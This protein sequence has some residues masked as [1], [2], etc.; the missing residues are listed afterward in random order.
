MN[1]LYEKNIEENNIM[2]STIKYNININYKKR[3]YLI[4]IDFDILISELK[5][6]VFSYFK[7]D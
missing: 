3:N 1:E 4:T 2:N 7:I 6:I 5:K